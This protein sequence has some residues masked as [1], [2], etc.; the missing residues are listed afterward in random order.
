MAIAFE[1]NRFQKKLEELVDPNYVPTV[2]NSTVLT[3]FEF[4]AR[5]YVLR[6][7]DEVALVA[8]LKED[9]VDYLYNG[10]VSF[11]HAL[12]GLDSR[13]F[14]WSAIKL[15]YSI[16]YMCRY[17]LHM[18]SYGI[19]RTNKNT[20]YILVKQNEQ[21]QKF[22]KNNTHE[23]VKQLY[24]SKFPNA[25]ILSNNV[26]DKNALEWM[27]EVREII[28]YKAVRFYEPSYLTIFEKFSTHQA[29]LNSINAILSDKVNMFLTDYAILG[30]PLGFLSEMKKNGTNYDNLL[31]AERKEYLKNI[32]SDDLCQT[33]CDFLEI[34]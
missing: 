23:S 1:R 11:C 28:N 20:Y 13:N 16:F 22:K 18:N 15:Y 25:S 32:L 14:S 17:H 24:S 3:Q 34:T 26:D 2:A 8:L 21:L 7:I 31:S 4:K 27:K 29:I 19:F 30:I 10:I 9:A 5:N 12:S 33:I 6:N